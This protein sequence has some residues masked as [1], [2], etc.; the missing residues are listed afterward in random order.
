MW[1]LRL[2]ALSLLCLFSTSFCFA[3]HIYDT[4][5]KPADTK[6]GKYLPLLK[7]KRVA[8]IINQTSVINDKSLLDILLSHKVNVVKIFVPEHGFRGS[9]D[10]GAKVENTTDSATGIPVIS[11]YGKHKKPTKE[12]LADVDVMLYD[13]QDVGVRFYTYIS[14]LE[15]CMEACAQE[16]KKIIVLDRPNPNGF[17]VDGPVL[18]KE[19]A[20]FVGLQAIPIVYGMTA[21][22]YAKMLTGERWYANATDID[23]E[24][25]RCINYTHGK[26]Y[27]LPVAPS[28]NL[29]TMAAV[30]AYPSLCLF[31]GTVVSV[32]RG[33]DLPFQQY[34]CPEFEWA[35]KYS[36]TPKSGYGAK[37]PPYEN[38]ECYGELVGVDEE[39]VLTQI[40]NRFCIKWLKGAYTAYPDKTKFFTQF[41]TKLSGTAKLETQLKNGDTEQLIRNT[42]KPGLEAFQRIRSKYLLYPD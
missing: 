3:G 24:V 11:L 16:H 17:Y 33:T 40:D 42:W 14:T 37:T 9:A 36:F 31:E 35:F 13:L 41:F 7:A 6:T 32:G 29:R 8:L 25:I 30:Y 20:S 2:W 10:A 22:E 1:Y 5:V 27:K 4:S 19:N 12:D 28:P 23:L 21:G 26:K 15:Y 34:G 18:E 39:Q 38:K